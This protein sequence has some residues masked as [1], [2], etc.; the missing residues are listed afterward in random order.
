[1]KTDSNE[2]KERKNCNGK[3]KGRHGK[4]KKRKR[5]ERNG[6]RHAHTQWQRERKF[7]IAI[8]VLKNEYE[9]F[10][11][12]ENHNKGKMENEMMPMASG[13]FGETVRL[14][15]FNDSIQIQL[16]IRVMDN[17]NVQRNTHQCYPFHIQSFVCCNPQN[18][19]PKT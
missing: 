18:M 16:Y 3:T 5:R 11:N 4:G 1:M 6:E 2:C 15:Q 19:A 12:Q 10:E 13:R 9:E 14:P 17:E 7:Q 8:A